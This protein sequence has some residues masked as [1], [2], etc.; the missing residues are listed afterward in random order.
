MIEG[1]TSSF[2][3]TAVSFGEKIKSIIIRDSNVNFN[4]EGVC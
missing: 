4:W 2:V 1:I 3:I